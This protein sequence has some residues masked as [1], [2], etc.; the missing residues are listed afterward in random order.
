MVDA[1]LSYVTD[2]SISFMIH[3]DGRKQD[4]QDVTG[5]IALNDP[6]VP[7]AILFQSLMPR[8]NLQGA[9]QEYLSLCSEWPRCQASAC[10][11]RPERHTPF[12]ACR[13]PFYDGA[14]YCGGDHI[15]IPPAMPPQKR[16]LLSPLYFQFEVLGDEVYAH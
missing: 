11:T 6:K 4:I 2:Q 14:D 7:I 8:F 3:H 10:E 15:Q 9:I 16:L 1:D 12:D 13:C 5:A